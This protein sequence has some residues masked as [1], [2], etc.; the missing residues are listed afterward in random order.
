MSTNPRHPRCNRIAAARRI[1][2]RARQGSSR[3]RR[4]RKMRIACVVM[5]WIAWRAGTRRWG[6]RR[7]RTGNVPTA[8]AAGSRTSR[9]RW[10]ARAAVLVNSAT[11]RCLHLRQRPWLAMRA[12]LASTRRWTGRSRATRVQPGSTASWP[13]WRRRRSRWRAA[14][15]VTAR[16]RARQARSRVFCALRASTATRSRRG[17]SRPRRAQLVAQTS[18]KT[19]RA[20]SHA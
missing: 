14:R 4:Q 12:V 13:W 9:I 5:F 19:R 16:T 15:A 18:T 20:R 1:A 10:H 7:T 6:R 3:L 11:R 17:R 8:R 2:Q